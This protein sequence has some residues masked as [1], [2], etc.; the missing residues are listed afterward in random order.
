MMEML[1]SSERSLT[2]ASI[3]SAA[4]WRAFYSSLVLYDLICFFPGAGETNIVQNVIHATSF[5][6]HRGRILC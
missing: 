1:F 3:N 2:F 4:K 5:K 6:E